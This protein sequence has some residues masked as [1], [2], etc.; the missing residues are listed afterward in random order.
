[1]SINIRICINVPLITIVRYLVVSSSQI[2]RRK[3]YSSSVNIAP[4]FSHNLLSI[5]GA[6]TSLVIYWSNGNFGSKSFSGY[7]SSIGHPAS[8]ISMRLLGSFIKSAKCFLAQS[9][10]NCF[11]FFNVGF[12]PVPNSITRS[13]L[14]LPST[15]NASIPCRI[16]PT[17]LRAKFGYHKTLPHA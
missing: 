8:R 9:G 14:V 3:P 10:V 6:N 5:S 16:E 15:A 13:F 17:A 2:S 7:V 12:L 1:M 11:A 4:I